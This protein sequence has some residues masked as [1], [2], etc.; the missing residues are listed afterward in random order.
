[1]EIIIDKDLERGKSVKILHINS[2]FSSSPFYKNLFDKQI[3]SRLDI[4]VFVPVPTSY[5]PTD[6]DFGLYS[7]LSKNHRKYDRLMFHVK[8]RK[9][10]NDAIKRF[11]ISEYSIVHA[12][13]LFSNGYIA[14]KL[15]Q[16]FDVP[17]IVAVRNTDVNVFFKYFVHLRKLGIQILQEADKVIF[18]SE[19]YRDAVIEKY[20]PDN[21]KEKINKKVS[22][23]PNGIDDFWR[24]NLGVTKI[25]YDIN[26]L[27]LLYVGVIDKNKN[28]TT[29]VKAIEIL[30]AKGYNIIF[31]II[32]R[33]KDEN[34]F[35]R[36]KDLHFVNYISPRP[37]EDLIEIYRNNDIFIMPSITETFGLV[38]AEA[39]SQ[40][41]PV[42]YSKGQGFDG[43]Y[44][45]G[46]VGYSVNCFDAPEI[47][48][49][50]ILIGEKYSEISAN[51]IN[52]SS[53]YR[54]DLI[55]DEYTDIYSSCAD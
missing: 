40:G 41:L 6:I 5:K 29:T 43:Q 28:I 50:L 11:Q 1:M 49:K 36:I 8:H 20:I 37:K 16:Q 52:Q 24:E 19:T 51:C 17:Y 3:N 34:I 25:N 44:R 47:A 4:D 55:V 45:N 38:Y 2:Y 14:L 42:I 54:W 32:G 33:I 10:Y 9:I 27:K 7:T 46:S 53:R 12:H 48:T 26:N 30:Q 15:K 13:S 21:L 39:M 22:I 35:N 23:I 31:T 18:L